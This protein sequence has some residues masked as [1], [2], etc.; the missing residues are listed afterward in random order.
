MHIER[1]E[2]APAV[3]REAIRQVSQI[4]LPSG[5]RL[6]WVE[7][8][9]E[10]GSGR[11][12]IHVRI[13][14]RTP[15]SVRPGALAYASPFMQ[16]GAIVVMHDRIQALAARTPRLL[17]PLLAHVLAHEIGHV[18]QRTNYHAPS[19]V[20]K[21]HWSSED[22]YWMALKPLSFTPVDIAMIRDGL[23]SRMAVAGGN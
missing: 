11:V 23:A 2:L 8:A 4:F 13:S 1:G 12:V 20:M 19:G 5:V 21:G 22:C 15:P 9:P 6:T 10:A 16:E 14:D 17:T 7:T 3:Y 18:L